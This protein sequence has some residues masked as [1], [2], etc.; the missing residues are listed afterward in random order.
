MRAEDFQASAP[1]Q[2]LPTVGGAHAFVPDPLPEQFELT[3]PTVRLLARAE[4]ALGRLAGTTGRE[5]N[6][7]LVGSPMLHREAILSSRIEGTITTPEQLVLVQAGSDGGARRRIDE[8]TQEVLNYI[9]A[10]MR[11]LEL[12]RELP[13]C[14]RLIRAVHRELLTGVRGDQERPGEFRTDQNWVRGKLDDTVLNARFVPPPPREMKQA[15]EELERYLNREPSSDHDPVL[16]QLAVIHYQFETIHPFRDGNGRVGRL[17]IPLLLCSYGRLDAPILYLS[18]FFERSRD[19]YVD[20]LLHVSQTGEWTPWIDFFLRGVL[21][22]SE[23]A[24]QQATDLLAL[25]QKYHRQFQTGRSS[26][27]L[28]RLIDRLFQ[29]PSITIRSAADLL[30]VSQQA[31]SNNIHKL[32][33]AGILRETTGKSRGQVFLAREILAFMYDRPGDAARER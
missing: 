28:I 1:G 10:M 19:L 16:V 27:L 22:S 18:A 26:A 6:P 13:V 11:G 23:E 33:D 14:L 25:R 15:L 4:N 9:D 30:G 3:T 24:V 21:E 31:A 7:Y 32:V 17:L 5:F 29:A 2:L 12:L 20:L 8:D